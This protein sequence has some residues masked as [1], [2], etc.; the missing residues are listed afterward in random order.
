LSR[1]KED[2]SLN[3]LVLKNFLENVFLFKGR[4]YIYEVKIDDKAMI[5]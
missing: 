2:G 4:G 1:T 5:S 3:S